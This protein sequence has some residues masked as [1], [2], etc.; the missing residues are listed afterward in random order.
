MVPD[1]TTLST[2]ISSAVSQ[3]TGEVLER[4]GIAMGKLEEFDKRLTMVKEDLP[5]GIR[6]HI[7][8]L[9]E[10][11]NEFK[12]ELDVLPRRVLRSVTSSAG[13][14]KGKIGELATLMRLLGEYERLIP[15]G[16]PVDFIGIGEYIDFVET[17]TGVSSLTPEQKK[18]RDLIVNRKVRFVL[19]REDVEITSP[20]EM[21]ADPRESE[22]E[23]E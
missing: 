11:L 4:L 21:L 16:E 22:E 12:G 7:N 14:M 5:D 20:G 23:R 18:I 1:P 6:R 10:Y 3:V 13:Q 17:K 8:E 19:R 2:V 15:L 9:R